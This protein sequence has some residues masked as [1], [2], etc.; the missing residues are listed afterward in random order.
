ML[1]K[2]VA[3]INLRDTRNKIIKGLYNHMGIMVV[4]QEQIPEKPKY[5]YL[6]YK[7]IV[8]Y[9]QFAHQGN[10]TEKLVPSNN[11]RFEYDVEETLELQPQMTLSI[12]AYCKGEEDGEMIAQETAIKAMQWFK[13]VGYQE[14]SD[15]NVVVVS[16]EAFGDRSTLMVDDY[17]HRI[18]F[19]VILR[20]TDSI[21]RRLET[22]EDIKIKGVMK[23]VDRGTFRFAFN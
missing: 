12:S 22:M 7:F 15:I 16:I 4:P 9:N 23:G 8:P 1:L 10:Y 21:R 20:T 17:E 5:P 13:H 18:G 6:A 2:G 11:N 3:E 14:L 19:D